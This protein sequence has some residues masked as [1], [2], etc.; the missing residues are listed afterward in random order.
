MLCNNTY[1]ILFGENLKTNTKVNISK[2]N[3]EFE[4]I[5]SF[6]HVLMA[7]IAPYFFK[8]SVPH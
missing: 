3:E 7:N 8:I 6:F 5:L 1:L 4:S 2:K